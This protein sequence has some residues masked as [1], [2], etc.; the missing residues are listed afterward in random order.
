MPAS[1]K[2]AFTLI[3]LLVVVSVIAIVLALLIPALGLLKQ[4]AKVAKTLDLMQHVTTALTNYLAD[5]PMLGPDGDPASKAFAD[6]PLQF[7]VIAQRQAKKEPYLE[8]EMRQMAKGPGPGLQAVELLSEVEHILDHFPSPDRA[9]RL[10][11]EIISEQL[12]SSTRWFTKQVRVISTAGTP[13]DPKDDLIF[14]YT[15]ESGQW[16]L[17]KRAELK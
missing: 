6:K 13:N 4:K 14:E 1:P 11:F 15:T 17:K 2:R 12:A 9:N 7:L 8:L 10:Q 16:E 5:Y 3:E